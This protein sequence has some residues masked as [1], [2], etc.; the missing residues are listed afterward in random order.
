MPRSWPLSCRAL[1]DD[2]HGV[3]PVAATSFSS[4]AR[5]DGSLWIS[6]RFKMFVCPRRCTRR[7]PPV[8]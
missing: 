7:I 4:L 5:N 1:N 8:S 3:G 6:S 2:D